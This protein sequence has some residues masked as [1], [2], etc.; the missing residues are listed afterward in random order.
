M[1]S[2]IHHRLAARLLVASRRAS[3]RRAARGGSGRGARHEPA[4][5]TSTSSPRELEAPS[6]DGRGGGGDRRAAAR[7]ELDE[8]G[9][10]SRSR[11]SACRPPG[12]GSA[13]RADLFRLAAEW[14]AA[15]ARDGGRAGSSTCSAGTWRRSGRRPLADAADLGRRGDGRS[16]RPVAERLRLRRSATRTAR[17]SSTSRVPALLPERR[18][19]ARPLPRAR[20][21]PSSSCTRGARQ[22]CPSVSAALVF[23]TKAPQSVA[24][25]LVDGAVAGSWRVERDAKKSDSPARPVRAAPA[26]RPARAPRGGRAPRPLPR[27]RRDVVRGPLSAVETGRSGVEERQLGLALAAQRR[28]VDLRP[29]RAR[30]PRT[31][32]GPGA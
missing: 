5:A 7:E 31:A 3:A 14:L 28:E 12:P 9:R 8:S 32:S 29:S 16:I 11:S 25:F 4:C 6:R 19:R 1:R 20:G 21:T 10:A 27:A 24:T 2:T 15:R 18:R 17:S 23:S 26:A 30:A 22:S 13:R